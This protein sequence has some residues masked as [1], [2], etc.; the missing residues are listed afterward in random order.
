MIF[1]VKMIL[2]IMLVSLTSNAS[3]AACEDS[4][5]AQAARKLRIFGKVQIDQLNSDGSTH[6]S[7][8]DH[9]TSVSSKSDEYAAISRYLRKEGLEKLT[10][11]VGIVDEGAIGTIVRDLKSCEVK[12]F[13]FS[14]DGPAFSKILDI[15]NNS[16]TVV[17]ENL[18]NKTVRVSKMK[19]SIL[20]K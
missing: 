9:V 17:L 15:T 20:N 1:V 11:V 18:S 3:F 7:D 5:L 4:S 6:D 10:K 8:F 12:L 16:I 2:S 13:T 14:E 19:K